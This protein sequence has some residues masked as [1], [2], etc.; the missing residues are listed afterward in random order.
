[1]G[2]PRVMENTSF[3]DGTQFKELIHTVSSYKYCYFAS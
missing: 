2:A 3:V 1:M